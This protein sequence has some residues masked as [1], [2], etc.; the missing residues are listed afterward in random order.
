MK[1]KSLLSSTAIVV[2]SLL[3]AGQAQA[4]FT[5]TSVNQTLTTNYSGSF[6]G[7]SLSAVV[8]YKLTSFDLSNNRATFSVTASNTTANQSG[9]NRLA[10]FGVSVVNPDI[11]SVSNIGIDDFSGSVN[12][13]FEGAAANVD[14]CLYA[15]GN[16]ANTQF[17]GDTIGEGNSET[18]NMRLNF[19]NGALGT[20]QSG[21][22]GITFGEPYVVRFVSVGRDGSDS[23][24]R[25]VTLSCAADANPSCSTQSRV[26]P[27]PASLAPLAAAAPDSYY[28]LAARRGPH[29]VRA[30]FAS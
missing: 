13:S 9:S 16:C 2:A 10:S 4:A 15:E 7:V 1:L 3:G 5:F 29:V 17:G 19:S 8:T 12:S 27:E 23:N 18:G 30:F 14:L 22:L 11:T 21:F 6:Q 24:S 26:I 20:S 28:G 25:E